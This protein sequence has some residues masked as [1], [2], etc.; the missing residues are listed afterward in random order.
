MTLR[1]ARHPGLSRL[2]GVTGA[3]VYTCRRHSGAVVAGS[4]RRSRD[5]AASDHHSS[6]RTPCVCVCVCVCGV[7][8]CE[9]STSSG[10][11]AYPSRW[12]VSMPPLTRL[13]LDVSQPMPVRAAALA[14]LSFIAPVVVCPVAD[15]LTPLEDLSPPAADSDRRPDSTHW[16][17]P[18][19]RLI[20]LLH[21]FLP[22]P[23]GTATSSVRHVAP[24]DAGGEDAVRC[25]LVVKVNSCL[26]GSWR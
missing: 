12:E 17:Q 25:W 18:T 26:C 14:A 16:P 7:C 3:K 4:G 21:S 20:A 13:V 9:V 2:R 15:G 19:R 8:V 1:L 11:Q 10:G 24:G 6:R 22:P 5:P 23:A